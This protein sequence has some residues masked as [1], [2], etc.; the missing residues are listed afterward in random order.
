VSAG[1]RRAWLLFC[2]VSRRLRRTSDGTVWGVSQPARGSVDECPAGGTVGR[3][4]PSR[5]AGPDRHER[6]R[7]RASRSVMT[8]AR[9][10]GQFAADMESGDAIARRVPT[11]RTALSE[12]R[13]FVAPRR[14]L[15]CAG[16]E[17]KSRHF[18]NRQSNAHP[19]PRPNCTRSP[20]GSRPASGG[21]LRRQRP[22]RVRTRARSAARGSFRRRGPQ[23]PTIDAA[24]LSR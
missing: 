18:L 4:V 16:T 24:C 17:G 2:R 13:R 15:P 5:A 9:S 22:D 23:P 6:W 21:R 7:I 14:G 19:H 8:T 10:A 1:T 11:V 3:T 20:R 12:T